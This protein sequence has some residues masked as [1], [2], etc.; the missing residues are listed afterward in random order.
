MTIRF[1]V[2]GGIEPR[3]G[4]TYLFEAMSSSPKRSI[5][6]PPSVVVGGHSFQDYA[7]RTWSASI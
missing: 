6:R 1:I 4:S 3:K 2:R 7:A 5:Q